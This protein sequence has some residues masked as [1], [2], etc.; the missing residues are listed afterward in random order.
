M[1][2]PQW[3]AYAAILNEAV[4]HNIGFLN[5]VLY[6]LGGSNAFHNATSMGSDFMHVGSGS[7]N[8]D[9]IQLDA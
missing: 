8:L 1:A 5:P 2:A 9:A 4:G 3:A 7:P 6:P